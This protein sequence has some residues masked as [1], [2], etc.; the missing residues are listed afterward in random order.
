MGA[1]DSGTLAAL[2]HHR[3]TL[4]DP[5]VVAHNGRIVKLIGD[6]TLVEFA[7]VIDAV[8]LC[9]GNF[10]VAVNRRASEIR[11]DKPLRSGSVSISAT[12]LSTA[13]IFMAMASMSP[14]VWSRWPSLA[15]SASHRSSMKA[16]QIGSASNS[17][18]AARCG[19]KT[20]IAQYA[21]GNGTPKRTMARRRRAQ[22]RQASGVRTSRRLPSSLLPTCPGNRNR[23]I[24]PTGLPTIS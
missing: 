19:S 20:L 6:G 10:S 13:T 22:R 9:V 3:E 14:P 11:P 8:N 12:S 2:K 18:T 5:A 7:S 17:W 16:W 15:A 4:F 24:F 1:D 21:S 23:N